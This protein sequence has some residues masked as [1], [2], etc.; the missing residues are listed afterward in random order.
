MAITNQIAALQA[1]ATWM[2]ANQNNIL[3]NDVSELVG[4]ISSSI[5]QTESALTDLDGGVLSS[6]DV[7][8][9]AEIGGTLDVTGVVTASSD[10]DVTGNTTVGGTLDVTG[11]AT[12]DSASVTNNATVGGTL[13]VTG[14]TTVGGTLDVTGAATLDSASVT[15]N[16]T[17][18]GTLDVTGVVTASSA[19]DVTGNTTVGGTLG[20]TGAATLDSASVTN[21]ATVG[22][23]LGVTSNATVG[24]TLQV[25]GITYLTGFL[26]ADKM[27]IVGRGATAK[28]GSAIATAAELLSGIITVD[29]SGGAANLTTPSGS[30]ISAAFI[31]LSSGYTFQVQVLALGGDAVTLVG[32]TGVTV[33]AP[34]VAA[35][36]SRIFTFRKTGANTYTTY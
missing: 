20:V 23:T 3:L 7:T 26:V 4:Q 16:T 11:A 19:L 34:T 10:L 27:P 32:D 8:G 9:N 31:G 6:L 5:T 13:D 33:T 30:A 29:T 12:L 22:G 28:T 2:N 15:N 14:N 21:N 17:I 24:G 18:G 25:T 36:S 35:N 1:I